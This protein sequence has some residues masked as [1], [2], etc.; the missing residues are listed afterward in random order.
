YLNSRNIKI[1]TDLTKVTGEARR[2]LYTTRDFNITTISKRVFGSELP[3]KTTDE[4]IVLEKGRERVELTDDKLIIIDE[5]VNGKDLF[6]DIDDLKKAAYKYL[7][8]LG[9]KKRNLSLRSEIYS[10]DVKHLTL[11]EK[12]QGALLF[13]QEINISL[14]K[15]GF[16]ELS[17]PAK[18]V[19][20][21]T[22]SIEVLTP[23][24]LLVMA[25][26]PKGSVVTRID[27]GYKQIN[28][29]ELYDT[30]VWCVILDNNT[31]L[32]Y[33]ACTGEKLNE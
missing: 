5:I 14:H 25:N 15:D 13:D 16:L 3:V 9:Y 22:A 10:D 23:Y 31:Q 17:I 27:F 18:I 33:N 26:L 7:D 21:N 8:D 11:I 32:F 12:Y 19:K 4:F 1:Q 2:I 29:G 24:Q 28:E 6:K 30:P 20:K